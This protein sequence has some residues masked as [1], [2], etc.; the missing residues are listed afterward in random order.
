MGDC[1]TPQEQAAV[2]GAVQQ[3][4]VPEEWK[5][6]FCNVLAS[7]LLKVRREGA[8]QSI[9]RGE[10]EGVWNVIHDRSQRSSE[11]TSVACSAPAETIGELLPIGQC[12]SGAAR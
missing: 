1:G 12:R 10:G 7:V 8:G 3:A 6:V 4:A 5:D 2:A 11:T 9:G